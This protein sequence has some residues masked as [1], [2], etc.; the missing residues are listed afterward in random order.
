MSLEQ[1]S[2]P[3]YKE[4]RRSLKKR[5]QTLK[6][7]HGYVILQERLRNRMLKLGR[8]LAENLA[9]DDT[10]DLGFDAREFMTMVNEIGSHHRELLSRMNT[11]ASFLTPSVMRWNEELVAWMPALRQIAKVQITRDIYAVT[12]RVLGQLF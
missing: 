5:S 12:N 1:R 10:V 11:G 4:E 3:I 7:L 8:M 2:D 9:A 6:K